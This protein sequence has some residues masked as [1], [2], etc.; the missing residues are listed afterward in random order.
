MNPPD[1]N[2][3]REV[4]DRYAPVTAAST[5]IVA[6]FLKAVGLAK[7]SAP[8]ES[9]PAAQT[10]VVLYQ[11]RNLAGQTIA[12]R[13]MR[14]VATFHEM[15]KT[16]QRSFAQASRGDASTADRQQ[17]VTLAEQVQKDAELLAAACFIT[18]ADGSSK[19]KFTLEPQPGHHIP[20]KDA[21]ASVQG[22]SKNGGAREVEFISFGMGSRKV[23]M[24]HAK[25]F[26]KAAQKSPVI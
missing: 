16:L 8:A 2:A 5:G 11:T 14:V 25:G 13:D 26:R 19:Y 17:F 12:S 6:E 9:G 1:Q 7:E 20:L 15:E 22:R 18:Q 3:L 10:P 23:T 4:M 24:M 21:F